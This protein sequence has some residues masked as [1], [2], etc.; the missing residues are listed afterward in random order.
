MNEHRYVYTIYTN[1]IIYIYIYAYTHIH[2]CIYVYI[3]I[4][5]YVYAHI[6]MYAYIYIYTHVYMH[7]YI[8]IYIYIGLRPYHISA[9]P[10]VPGHRRA[11]QPHQC[12]DDDFAPGEL[13]V[14]LLASSIIYIYIYMNNDKY[15]D[16]QDHSS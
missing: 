15:H 11:H 3:G 1:S 2:I 12:G 10:V 7:T 4:Y 16:S 5:A 14:I 8:Y 6:F 13:I 9:A